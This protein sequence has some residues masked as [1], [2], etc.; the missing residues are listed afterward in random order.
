MSACVLGMHKN[1]V[2]YYTYLYNIV[3]DKRSNFIAV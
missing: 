3:G 2:Q 1:R